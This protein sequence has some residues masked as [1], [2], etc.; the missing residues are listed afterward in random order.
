MKK[1]LIVGGVAGG[2]TTATR[3]RR[4][5]EDYEIIVFEKGDYVS[6][7]NCGLPYHLGGSIPNRESLILQT[8]ESL[9]TRFNL[10]IRI[11]SE[12]TQIFPNEK[13]IKI[14]NET[15][16]YFENYDYLVLSPGAKPIIPNIE[17]INNK[18]IFTLRNIA[19]MDRIKSK[20][21][22]NIKSIAVIG[23]GFIGIECA[24]N[25]KNLGID[26]TLVEANS[27]ILSNFDKEMANIL[28][29][30]IRDKGVN[31]ILN[32][33]VTKFETLDNSIN[34]FLKSNTCV[35][36]D[37]II[38]AIGVTPDT[39]FLHNSGIALG[40]KGHILVNSKLKTN[41]EDIY[42][43]GDSILVENYVTR[44]TSFIPLAGPANRQGRIVADNIFGK[45]K[46]YIGSLG[47]SI[48]K[49]F[50]FSGATTGINEKLAK[51]LNL[52]YEK[53][54]LHPNNHATYYPNASQISIKV[55]YEKNS[56]EILGAQAIGIDGV[57]KFIDT[58][59]TTLKFNGTI[60]DLAELELAYA[61]PYL[62][63]KS[64]AN[65]VG[66]IGQNIEENLFTQ[67]FVDELENF[68][69]EHHFLIDVRE[70]VECINNVL[71]NSIN[72]P[73]TKLRNS[74][75]SIPK[76][77]EIWVYCAV[78]LR[79]Y[80]ACRFLSQNGYNVKNIAGGIKTSSLIFNNST[81][82]ENSKNSTLSNSSN[83]EYIDLSGLSCP[84]PLVTIK[85]KI[86]TLKNGEC[87][88]VKVSDSGFYNDI[89]S[90]CK[91]TNNTLLDI[92]KD[93][94]STFATIQKGSISANKNE[95]II[96]N[97]NSE[98]VTIVVF[99]G[100][101]D[102]AIASFIIANGA[103]ALGKKVTMFFTF[104]GLSIIKKRTLSK[105]NILEK[106]FSFMLPKNS[107]SL[108]VSK[109][110]FFGIGAKMIRYVMKSKDI[111][112]LEELMN[113]SI[114]NGVNLIACSMSM[115]VMGIS[116]DELLENI[117]YGG[118]GQYLGEAQ[119]SNTNL[120]I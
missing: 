37:A 1:I 33:G 72:I 55:L 34:V 13:K 112:S 24:E 27:Q 53:I 97:E 114:E 119:N 118:V 64:P 90:W 102:K 87:L 100:D 57:D 20:L 3:L 94:N 62:S 51:T 75:N 58:I 120:F 6:F 76:D 23:G 67:I 113:K 4:L 54:Y 85:E 63:A 52:D 110:N 44:E 50:D 91:V 77:K 117:E 22:E 83:I 115:D 82:V 80:L 95:N 81:K 19:D 30:E 39:N 2:A 116:K 15:K 7:A 84:G 10:D 5:S 42:A 16:E 43:L 78:G 29:N 89:K 106:M 14:K 61:P 47:T 73:L 8:P 46:D 71:K 92:K 65:M 70:E 18:N 103:L 93:N 98:S 69:P 96:I 48:I 88:K 111:M 25:M 99:S 86:E 109:M 56:K 108:P 68:N 59:A 12:V 9:K 31:L 17:G 38:L 41:Y 36:V 40:E 26:T 79:G 11:K 105:N 21:S 107:L 45:N 49:V 60:D 104:W 101:L 74:L 66:F 28:E 35:T 32:D